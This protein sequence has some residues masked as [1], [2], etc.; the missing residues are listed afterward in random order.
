MP[1]EPE[2]IEKIN[3]IFEEVDVKKNGYIPKEDILALLDKLGI[4]DN[5]S[6]GAQK[7]VVEGLTCHDKVKVTND[8]VENFYTVIKDKDDLGL[9]KICMRGV[10]EPSRTKVNLQ[11]AMELSTILG[12]PKT[13]AELA[14]DDDDKSFSFSQLAEIFYGIEIPADANQFDG[15][16]LGSTCCL[17]L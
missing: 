14:G 1:L 7:A 12:I 16:Q 2:E 5:L 9:L 13:Q 4:K 8:I 6:E 15:I 3:K 17:L 10:T 11:E